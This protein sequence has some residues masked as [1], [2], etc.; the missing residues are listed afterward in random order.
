MVY[1]FVIIWQ[2]N[3]SL[4]VIEYFHFVRQSFLGYKKMIN[5]QVLRPN[6]SKFYWCQIILSYIVYLIYFV[7]YFVIYVT[8]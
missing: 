3:V 8:V 5:I 2:C 1:V 7:I 4:S 6:V